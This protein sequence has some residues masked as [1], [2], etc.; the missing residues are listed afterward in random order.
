MVGRHERDRPDAGVL[1]VTVD[2]ERRG[3]LDGIV[4]AQAVRPREKH[5][6]G[7]ERRCYLH[8][9]VTLGEMAAEMAEDGTA[10]RG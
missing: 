5:A 3:E 10:V 8:D 1:V 9:D 4:G 2:F 6:G 7:Q